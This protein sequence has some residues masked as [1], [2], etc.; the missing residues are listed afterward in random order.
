MHAARIASV[1]KFMLAKDLDAFLFTDPADVRWCC[2][3]T[4]SSGHFLIDQSTAT[5]LTDGRY[6]NQAS[7][8][9][10]VAR[11]VIHSGSAVEHISTSGLLDHARSLAV[12]SSQVSVSFAEELETRFPSVELRA[13][14][15]PFRRRIAQKDADEI[16]ALRRAQAITDAVFEEILGLIRPGLSEVEISTEIIRRHLLMGAEGMSFPPIVASGPN[17][18]LP[19]GRPTE[20]QIQRGELVVLDFG[21]FVDGYASDMTR[22]VAVGAP[23]KDAVDVYDVV[24]SAQRTAQEAARAGMVAS[25]LDA[26]ARDLITDAGYGGSFN[27]SLGHGLGL[28]IHEWPRIGRGCSEV[29]PKNVVITIEPGIYIAESF[30]IR[31][32]NSVL[33]TD[34][35]A[36]QLPTSDTSLI[37]I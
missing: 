19:H 7:T 35:G 32:E 6:R 3:F 34:S 26:I 23:E 17:G 25:E 1:R 36:E 18:A 31:I 5:L 14:P 33:L 27:H 37:V 24:H 10:S 21:C 28:R 22:T 13:I 8:E 15:A 16:A 11:V 30:G 29:L 9:V 2:G 20:K 12:D 4:G